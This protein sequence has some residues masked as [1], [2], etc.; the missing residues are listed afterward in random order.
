MSGE[1]CARRIANAP[2]GLRSIGVTCHGCVCE[3]A[4]RP[5][6]IMN[7][8]VISGS[9]PARSVVRRSSSSNAKDV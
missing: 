2:S 9:A 8:A 6:F 1:R 3:S 4:N 5:P 7:T